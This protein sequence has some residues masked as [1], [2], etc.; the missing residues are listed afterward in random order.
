M[1]IG[2]LKTEIKTVF[3][4]SH[5]FHIVKIQNTRRLSWISLLLYLDQQLLGTSQ[6]TQDEVCQILNI[7]PNDTDKLKS[8]L[9]TFICIKD[10]LDLEEETALDCLVDGGGDFGTDAVYIDEENDGGVFRCPYP[11]KIRQKFGWK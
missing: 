8:A 9:F 4:S 6:E 11:V 5:N 3:R 7:N 2:S 1:R 10:I